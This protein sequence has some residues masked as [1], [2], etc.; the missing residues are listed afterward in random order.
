VDE[1]GENKRIL[2]LDE[3]CMLQAI[4]TLFFAQF[5]LLVPARL[6]W[7]LMFLTWRLMSLLILQLMMMMIPMAP[8]N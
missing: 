7:Q 3:S 1:K 6:E 4:V 5:L 8:R 2:Q